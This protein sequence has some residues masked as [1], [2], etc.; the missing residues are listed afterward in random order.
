MKVPNREAAYAAD[1]LRGFWTYRR[2]AFADRDDMFD[3]RHAEG[4]GPPVFQPAHADS[5]V[6]MPPAVSPEIAAAILAM[7]PAAERHRWFGSMRSSQ[8]LA[9]SVFA[10]L[11]VLGRLDVLEGLAA[12]DGAP[13]FFT[14]AAGYRGT[15]EYAVGTLGE[16]RP[17]SVDA[18]LRGPTTIAVEVKLAEDGFGR[19]SRPRLRPRDANFARDHCDGSFTVQR[20]R[21]TRCSLSEIGVRYWDYLPD[22]FAWNANEDLV[23]CPLDPT[24]QLARNVLAACVGADRERDATHAHALVIYD[25]RNPAFQSGGDADAQWHATRTALRDPRLLRRIS[26]QTMAARLAEAGDFGWLA[27]G[28]G[29]KYGLRPEPTIISPR[30]PKA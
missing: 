12:E 8:A 20:G 3:S 9:Q 7:T 22:L 10:N 24:Y 30:R 23:P 29:E 21:R 18:F 28:L 6:L 19:C 5:N 17:T 16:P 2:A 4:R 1:L 14:A 11:A 13:A 25:A 27:Q 15:L 26:W